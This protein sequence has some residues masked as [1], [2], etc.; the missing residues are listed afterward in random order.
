MTEEKLEQPIDA[1]ETPSEPAPPP[2]PPKPA[3]PRLGLNWD[4]V[5]VDGYWFSKAEGRSPQPGERR[6]WNFELVTIDEK[7]QQDRLYARV[8]GIYEN[9]LN[10]ARRDWEEK[11]VAVSRSTKIKVSPKK[12]M[13]VSS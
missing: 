1:P 3:E 4:V 5:P 7:N 2:E 12:I 10:L 13:V 11:L 9:A 6:V 8:D